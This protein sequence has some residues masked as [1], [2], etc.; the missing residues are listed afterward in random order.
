MWQD[1]LALLIVVIAALAL[2]RF[3]VPSRLFRFGARRGGD[4]GSMRNAPPGGCGGCPSGSSCFKAQGERKAAVVEELRA[5]GAK[6]AFIG[7]GV[8]DAPRC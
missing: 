4:G 6:V 5:Q 8:S 3:Y 1:G 2:L 7:D